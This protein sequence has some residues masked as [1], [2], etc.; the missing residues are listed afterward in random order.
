MAN[1]AAAILRL[2]SNTNFKKLSVNKHYF[3]NTKVV[4]VSM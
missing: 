4:K 1:Y 2:F 3:K